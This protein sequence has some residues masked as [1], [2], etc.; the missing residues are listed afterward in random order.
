MAVVSIMIKLTHKLPKDLVV[1][2]SGGVDSCAAVD[3]LSRNHYV[4]CAYFHHG[5]EHSEKALA[6]AEKF[7]RDRNL[8]LS[9]GFI[10]GDKPRNLS[11]EEW[12]RQERYNWLTW[13]K[14]QVITAHHLD[15]CV[16]TYI[17]NMLHG[18][19]HTIDATFFN[20]L[21]PFLT[22]PKSEFISWCER[23]NVPWL[24]DASNQDNKFMRNYIRNELV[25]K[26]LVVNPGLQKVVKKLV[27]SKQDNSPL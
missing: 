9:V 23:H 27:E 16:E 19:Q 8:L 5:T 7:C 10:S 2:F 6:F 21:R 14:S 26:M 12:W 1:A 15:D 4:R 24:E 25:P 13:H 11:W 22:T 20:V 17:F 18:K 3:F